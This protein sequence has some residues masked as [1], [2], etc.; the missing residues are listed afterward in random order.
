[1][2]KNPPS[3]GVLNRRIRASTKLQEWRKAVFA[4]DKYTC[5]KCG[6]RNC[7][8]QAHHIKQFAYHPELRFEVSNG[9][10]LCK[11]CH[12]EMP[13][14]KLPKQ[15]TVKDLVKDLDTIFSQFI[16][17]R[18]ADN[19]GI[20]KCYTSGV[21]I[22]YKKSQAGHYISRRHYSLR[23]DERN[24]QVQSVSDNIYNQGNASVFAK[25]LQEQ[26]GETILDELAAK[27]NNKF[28]LNDFILR[29]LIAEYT[30]KVAELKLKK[31]I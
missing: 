28:H 29:H 6:A 31:G 2:I 30:L 10:T 12:K 26:Y 17:L 7:Y 27:K 5:Q 21:F 18:V 25:R 22:H 15:K 9:Q 1:M 16:R 19:N 24:V 4:R 20:V 3:K 14:V 13:H 11:P 8:L 23:W